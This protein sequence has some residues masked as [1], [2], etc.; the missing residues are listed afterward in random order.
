[1]ALARAL[2]ANFDAVSKAWR[3]HHAAHGQG[4]LHLDL[5]FLSSTARACIEFDD[6]DEVDIDG[7]ANPREIIAEQSLQLA[8]RI[9]VVWLAALALIVLVQL[10]D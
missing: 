4:L 8:W 3:E 10:F 5:G 2:A 9:L 7:D 1:M 6:V